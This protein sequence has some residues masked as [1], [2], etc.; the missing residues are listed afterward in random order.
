MF[1]GQHL[2]V[3]RSTTDFQMKM[4]E[5]PLS[6][7]DNTRLEVILPRTDFFVFVFEYLIPIL[8]F[9][10]FILQALI[11]DVYSELVEDACLGLCFEVHRAVKQGYF[12]LDE[13][14][15]DSIKEFGWWPVLLVFSG[16]KKISP[17]SPGSFTIYVSVYSFRNSGSARS[18][19][20]WSGV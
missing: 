4:E 18:G 11:Q 6:G 8:H 15:Q 12:F 1:P 19:H 7:P 16:K 17:Q 5:K 13:T 3:Q 10:L 14:D 20:I 9:I 2:K